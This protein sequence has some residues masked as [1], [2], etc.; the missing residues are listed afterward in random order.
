MAAPVT[1]T[2]VAK[3]A[4]V[5]QS[6]VSRSYTSG[7]SVSAGTRQKV[8][9]AAAQ[10]G[11]Q[12]NH[13]ARSLAT[14]RTRMVGLAVA[15]LENAF[16]ADVVEQLSTVLQR[17]GY[18]VLLFTLSDETETE[19]LLQQVINYRL[20]ALVAASVPLSSPLAASCRAN[21]IPVVLLNRTSAT[22]DS[23]SVTG[24]NERGAIEIARFLLAGGHTRFAYVAG[25]EDSS[26]NRDREGAFTAE[27]HGHEAVTL[28]RLAGNFD[29]RTAGQ[30]TEQLFNGTDEPPD[31]IFCANDW[32]A[33]AVLDVVR[34]SYG[35][36][37]PEDVS[38]VGFDDI[39]PAAWLSYGLTTYSQPVGAMVQSV[40]DI[41]RDVLA[42]EQEEVQN[43][44]VPGRLIIRS[45][46]RIPPF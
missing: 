35:L 44:R 38:I 9:A 40:A 36:R 26:T 39:A 7:A 14:R 16:Y 10:L 41:L 33:L 22:G 42:G 2:D 8:M 27:V 43:I 15:S 1:S 11:Y 23:S 30:V 17:L 19:S 4:G 29:A 25:L 18:H 21:G 5:S 37:V 20:D 28:R 45:S 12:P 6:A 32:M 46:A 13:I 3:L 34:F 24:D 31:A